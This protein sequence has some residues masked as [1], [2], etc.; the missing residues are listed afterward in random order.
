[1]VRPIEE[2]VARCCPEV[3]A[4]LLHPIGSMLHSSGSL[5]CLESAAHVGSSESRLVV[6]QGAYV[7]QEFASLR[8]LWDTVG[9]TALGR[10]VPRP[11]AVDLEHRLLLMSH[12]QLGPSLWSSIFGV[13]PLLRRNP[14]PAAALGHCGRWLAC[15]QAASAKMGNGPPPEVRDALDRLTRWPGPLRSMKTRLDRLLRDAAERSAPVPLVLSHG[16]FAPRNV[17]RIPGG[18][19]VVD[20]EMMSAGARSPG[21]D[22]EHFLVLLE[23]H[24]LWMTLSGR[25]LG[26]L[27]KAFV[28]GYRAASPPAIPS[29][30]R[31]AIR[32]ATRILVLDRQIKAIRRQPLRSLLSGRV[33][34]VRDVARRLGVAP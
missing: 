6:K 18:V 8:R 32:L 29:E 14:D 3:G 24:P 33:G 10:T 22:V 25:S 34:F 5:W 31:R 4:F 28:G 13:Q 20:W 11:V 19:A 15:F 7:D 12:L 27:V 26:D 30:S 17:H 9:D 16:D 21:F 23:R 1:M 2:L